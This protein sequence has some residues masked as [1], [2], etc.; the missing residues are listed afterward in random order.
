MN[1]RVLVAS[2]MFSA[3]YIAFAATSFADNKLI[4]AQKIE[5]QVVDGNPTYVGVGAGPFTDRFP[6]G[7]DASGNV[8]MQQPGKPAPATD[9]TQGRIPPGAT[10]KRDFGSIGASQGSIILN[11]SGKDVSEIEITTKGKDA[12][13]V[14]N[15]IH[16]NSKDG[17]D[18][19]A[20]IAGK[21]ITFKAKA[22]KALKPNQR[23]W[24]LI[25]P[26]PQPGMPG[27]KIYEG[28]VTTAQLVPPPQP[29][30]GG[31]TQ[32]AAVAENAAVSLTIAGGVQTLSL[33][34]G[35]VDFASYGDGSSAASP[36]QD[37]TVGSQVTIG[38]MVILGPSSLSGA[39]EL[40]D[41]GIA[42]TQS[43]QVIFQGELVNGLLIPDPQRSGWAQIQAQFGFF[44]EGSALPGSRFLR[45]HFG[46]AL[47][48]AFFMQSDLL[49][50]T[51]NLTLPGIGHGTAQI[52]AMIPE[53][54]NAVLM[55]FGLVLIASRLLRSRP[56]VRG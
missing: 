32:V 29:G 5:L 44:E 30:L 18:F 19:D 11:S 39:F 35:A 55:T 2:L 12:A 24:M 48:G 8:A 49:L 13:N 9:L 20:P 10:V 34:A 21:T 47:E 27:D 56:S 54:A 53:P 36:A 17:D 33:A 45:E 14:D 28:K 38:D 23:I 43:G 26:G 16:P 37:F 6:N 15:T 31:P 1:K 46:E 7:I 3:L 25:P 51:S 50:A 22:G 41:S 40:S 52:S 4:L 42:L